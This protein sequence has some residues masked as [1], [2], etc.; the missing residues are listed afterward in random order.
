MFPARPVPDEPLTKKSNAKKGS[1]AR[2]RYNAEPAVAIAFH[3]P[4][5]PDKTEYTFDVISA[6]LCD[7][8]S[9]WLEK[10][11]IYEKR[12]AKDV[13]CSV[14]FPGSRFDNLMLI[15][16]EPMKGRSNN[17]IIAAVEKE[18]SKLMAGDVSESDLRRVQKQV[19][20]SIVF[21][22]DS[23][24]KLAEALAQFETVFGDWRILSSY[25]ANIEKVD[26]AEIKSVANEYLAKS[27]MVVV[28]RGR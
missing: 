14:G 28:E 16:I 9:S 8:R 13:Y 1:R 6:L 27:E 25:P 23:N 5:L 21:S 24:E 12:L 17:A 3:K 7:G 20:A 19:T 10:S 4:T 2:V 15:W 22:L 26:A 18:L 11:L